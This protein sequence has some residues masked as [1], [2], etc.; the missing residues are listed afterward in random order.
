MFQSPAKAGCGFLDITC[1]PTNW[2][3]PVGGCASDDGGSGAETQVFT[4]S[5]YYEF[6]VKNATGNPVH[7]FI[8][9]VMYTLQ[10]GYEQDYRFQRTSGSSSGGSSGSHYTTTIHW[11]EEYTEGFQRRTFLLPFS[12][13]DSWYEFRLTDSQRIYLH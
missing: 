9:D 5:T 6:K 7:Y 4:P 2:T 12:G 11:D 8:N 3:C 1:S 13:Y 10:P